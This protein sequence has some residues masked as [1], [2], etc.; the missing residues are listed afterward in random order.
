MGERA[1]AA[2]LRRTTPG[3]R[4]A[5]GLALSNMVVRNHL[6]RHGLADPSTPD[7]IRRAFWILRRLE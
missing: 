4:F 6:A 3:E 5:H 7:E 2:Y 1:R